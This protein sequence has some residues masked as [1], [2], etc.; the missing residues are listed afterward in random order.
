MSHAKRSKRKV[1][2]PIKFSNS[3]HNLKSQEATSDQ[4]SAKEEVDP[5]NAGNKDETGSTKEQTKDTNIADLLKSYSTD[6]F[7]TIGMTY[8]T[9]PIGIEKIANDSGP[10]NIVNDSDVNVS[11]DTAIPIKS[12]ST[13]KQSTYANIAKSEL[14]N[15]LSFVPLVKNGDGED[16][17]VFYEVFV[18][19]GASRWDKTAYGYVIGSNMPYGVLQSNLRRMWNKYGIKDINM[20][21]KQICYFKFKTIEG[22]NEVI[23]KGPWIVNGKPLFVDK[24]SPDI[25]I[26][27]V[28]PTK[29]PMWVKLA[30][31]PLEAWSPKGLST[32]ASKLGTPL[33]MDNMTNSMCHKGVGRVGYARVMMEVE[34]AKGYANHVRPRTSAELEN[35]EKQKVMDKDGFEAVKPKKVFNKIMKQPVPKTPNK[36]WRL[37]A[38]NVKDLLASMNKYAV[39][40][41]N[42]D[43]SKSENDVL[44][45][46]LQNDSHL[47]ENEVNGIDPETVDKRM[48]YYCSF[49]YASNNGRQR[50][51]LWEE[52]KAQAIIVNKHPWVFMGDFNVTIGVNEHSS[53]CST[54]SGEMIEFNSCINDI[55][56]VVELKEKLQKCQSDVENNPHDHSARV[57][58]SN[59][60]LEYEREKQ[61]ELTLLRQKAKV[62]WLAEGDRNSK[63]FH[64]I[65]KCR[66]QKH[67]FESICDDQGTRFYGDEVGEQFVKHFKNFLGV[68]NN[69]RPIEE[70]GDIFNVKLFDQE[71]MDM[72]GPITNEEIKIAMFDID[73][74][75]SAGPDRYSA[76]F[77]KKAWSII[78]HDV[79]L[80]IKEFF[81]TGKLLRQVNTTLIALI[82]K[83]DTPN[84][85]SEYRPIACCNVLYKCIS[86]ILT[87]RLKSGLDKLV[88]CNQSAFLPER[89]IHDNILVAQEFGFHEKMVNWI[90]TCITSSSFSIC[91]NGEV[92]G[93]FK[94]GRGL[95]QGDPISPYLFTLVMEV[96][97]LLMKKF[98]QSSSRFK[99][100]FKCKGMKLTHIYFA[101]D[102]LVLCNGDVASVKVVKKVLDVFG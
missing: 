43:N 68:S 29:L 16:I 22:M 6:E 11:T 36:P 5:E 2:I 99:Y 57:V 9:T 101:D 8:K 78:G 45:S 33:G 37:N 25:N 34:A 14:D 63:L 48:K 26:E 95:R 17:V 7:P 77:F 65:V 39:L 58:A 102:L 96:F 40:S 90:M 44:E 91:V 61:D 82:P 13:R 3:V 47:R 100:H 46:S 93:F 10:I 35:K 84:K 97:S 83:I 54:I 88:S 21:Q 52:L 28:E 41:E 98:T 76:Q 30:N 60:F 87:N 31:V 55:E 50:S 62:K 59:T 19:E 71:A 27:K 75:K 81:D 56:N 64:S 66:K 80:A 15:K 20:D 49:I 23:D 79:C 85:V 67:K 74:N 92:E 18:A 12:Q 72:V 86:K 70:F 94:G 53:G 51:Q 4:S 69:C 32:I 42:E 73:G 89:S 24:W 38:N 1:R